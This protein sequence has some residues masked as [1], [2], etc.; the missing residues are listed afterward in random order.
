MPSLGGAR[1]HADARSRLPIFAIALHARAA[2][3]RSLS[4]S[5]PHTHVLADGGA[6][7]V[8]ASADDDAFYLCRNTKE[9]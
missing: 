5:P 3:V 2:N 7:A 4:H 1:A 6:P 8:L 9:L